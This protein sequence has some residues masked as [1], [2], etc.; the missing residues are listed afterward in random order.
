MATWARVQRACTR[1]KTG[2]LREKVQRA[3][4]RGRGAGVGP[5]RTREEAVPAAPDGS[6]TL[7]PTQPSLPLSFTS[8]TVPAAPPQARV[9]GGRWQPMPGHDPNSNRWLATPRLANGVAVTAADTSPSPNAQ[10]SPRELEDHR[11]LRRLQGV[12]GPSRLCSC[13]RKT[14]KRRHQTLV[15]GK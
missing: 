4:A 13:P 10:G 8:P 12:P 7:M 3:W 14:W 6:G 1:T 11:G 2:R 15:S 5:P 9:A